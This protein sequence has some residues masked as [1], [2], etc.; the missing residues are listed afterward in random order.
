L[1]K[2]CNGREARGVSTGLRTVAEAGERDDRRS[3]APASILLAELLG[4]S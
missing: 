4:E 3:T 1:L 2:P